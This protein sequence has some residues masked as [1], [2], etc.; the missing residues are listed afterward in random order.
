MP[1]IFDPEKAHI[2]ESEWRKKVFPPDRVMKFIDDIEG[3]RKNIAFDI[4]AGTGYLT[5]PL[6]KMFK[7][8]YAVEINVKMAE[9]LRKRIEDEKVLNVGIIVSEKPPEIDFHI[10][11]VLFS[12]VL[13]EMENPQ[14][15]LEWGSRADYV[16]VAEWKKEETE[17]GPPVNER[18]SLEEITDLSGYKM[19]KFE[20]LPFHYLAAFKT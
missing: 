16:V 2:L 19:V 18:L 9:K 3:L 4:G 10:D 14:E 1:H 11:L 15:Y 17:F 5:V 8:V 13:H 7:K 20:E 12:N 6:A